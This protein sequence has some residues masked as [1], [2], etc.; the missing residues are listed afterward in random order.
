MWVCGF[1]FHGFVVVGL[2]VGRLKLLLINTFLYIKASLSTG[3]RQAGIC[4]FKF[5]TSFA[6]SITCVASIRRISDTCVRAGGSFLVSH[7]ICDSRLRAFIR[8]VRC[9]GGYAYMIFFRAGGDGLFSRCDGVGGHC[10]RSGDIVLGRL[11]T[12]DNFEFRTPPCVPPVGRG[13]MI[14]RRISG[15]GG[16]ENGGWVPRRSSAMA[17]PVRVWGD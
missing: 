15:G 9:V 7:M 11:G 8:T 13:A 6:S 3:I 16:G 12:S 17:R 1:T 10:A 5:S 4:V 14:S 2:A